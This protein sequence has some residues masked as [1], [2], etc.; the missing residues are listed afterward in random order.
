MQKADRSD[1]TAQD[2]RSAT[3]EVKIIGRRAVLGA[4]ALAPL[5]ALGAGM[6][7]PEPLLAAT[8]GALAAEGRPMP[9]LE[10]FAAAWLVYWADLGNTYR[11]NPR[12][13]YEL[14][15][16]EFH[17]A[18]DHGMLPPHLAIWNDEQHS[19]AV[20]AMETLLK[21]VPGGTEAVHQLIDRGF[22]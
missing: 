3:K 8:A 18:R 6:L 7:A 5:A 10:G 15:L 20:R 19:G 4:A 2:G 11:R 12:G 1:S 14:G 21:I 17:V 9:A 22:E 13:G 16:M